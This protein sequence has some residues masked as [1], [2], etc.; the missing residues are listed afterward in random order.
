MF[1][2]HAV[3][4]EDGKALELYLEALRESSFRPNMVTMTIA[5]YFY[6]RNSREREREDVIQRAY[7]IEPRL[8]LFI[9]T[10]LLH[11]EV[12]KN[13][14]WDYIYKRYASIFHT[15]L[16]EEF[17]I[18]PIH[19]IPYAY[20][21][22]DVLLLEPRKIR[23]DHVS[24][25]VMLT[26]YVTHEPNIAKVWKLYLTYRTFLNDTR[27][28][29]ESRRLR[30]LLLRGAEKIPH[31]IMMGLGRKKQGLSYAAAVLEDML[32]DDAPI[33]A[34][35][36]TWSILVKFLTLAGKMEEAERVVNVM[37]ARGLA[38]NNVT[39]STLLAGYVKAGQQA[40]AEEVL[41]SMPNEKLVPGVHAWTALLSGYVK[42]G[43]SWEAGDA[44][45][46]MLDGDITP[47]DVTLQTVATVQDPAQFELGVANITPEEAAEVAAA[48][49]TPEEAA[50]LRSAAE[51]W[52]LPVPPP[53][54]STPDP[55]TWWVEAFEDNAAKQRLELSKALDEERA[56]ELLTKQ[57]E[58]VDIGSDRE[59]TTPLR[60]DT[61]S[62]L[63]KV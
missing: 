60:V 7:N 35:V 5:H 50:A 20:S 45:R 4:E 37:R 3:K 63:E 57:D 46:R 53:P 30:M 52:R 36:I 28:N 26:S 55:D 27:R 47:D 59:R 56:L 10:D 38:P 54:E 58:I 33:P 12:L 18:N 19:E 40:A 39:L 31:I 21:A 6:K 62:E 15:D 29:P 42:A 9:G 51:A 11:A 44:F 16:M 13:R 34:D 61:D 49:A 25:G 22:D 41:A 32:H 2:S 48:K 23:P 8:T 1:M 17:G 14:P 24:L 43:A